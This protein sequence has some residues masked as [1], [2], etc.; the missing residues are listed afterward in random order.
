M[1]FSSVIEYG[2]VSFIHRYVERDKRK[3]SKPTKQAFRKWS[4]KLFNKESLKK[5][6]LIPSKQ[7]NFDYDNK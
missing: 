3:R 6:L 5:A 1:T 4:K 2:I 7:K